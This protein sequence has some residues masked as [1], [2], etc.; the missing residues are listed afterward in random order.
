MSNSDLRTLR[1]VNQKINGSTF[2]QPEDVVRWMSAMQAQDYH[3]SV[4]AVGLRAA[5]CTLVD[6]ERALAEKKI[7]RTW[8]VRGTIHFVLPEDAQWMLRLSAPRMLAADHRRQEQLGLDVP[9]LERCKEIFFDALTAHGSLS[10]PEMMKTLQ[11]AG[12]STESQRSY[13]ILWYAAQTG[14]ICIGPMQ[15]KQQTFMLLDGLAQRSADLS[16]EEGLAQLA[17]RFYTSH[18]PAT[19]YDFSWWAGITVGEAKSSTES[20]RQGLESWVVDDKVYW[21]DRAVSDRASSAAKGVQLLPGFDEYLIGYKE[22]SAVLAG[23]HAQKIVPGN[24]GMF[25]PM[26]VVDGEVVGAWKRSVKKNKLEITLYPFSE[27]NVA[28]DDLSEAA[29]RYGKFMGLQVSNVLREAV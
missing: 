25:K 23:E 12:I 19:V 9:T 14:L 1:L 4:W 5:S 15:K 20:I 10:R 26:L 21:M 6:V 16:R 29:E 22:R 17:K 18:G 2:T 13:H 28:E 24:N 3:Q 11:N 8:P 7:V 27:L